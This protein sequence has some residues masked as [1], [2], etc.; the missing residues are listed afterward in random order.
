[1]ETEGRSITCALQVVLPL[2][3][4]SFSS[5]GV[6]FGAVLWEVLGLV[7]VAVALGGLWRVHRLTLVLNVGHEATVLVGG[8]GHRL[9]AAVGKID[10]VGP[11]RPSAKNV[12]VSRKCLRV[13]NCDTENKPTKN[14]TARVLRL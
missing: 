5:G 12:R 3:K 1:M 11:C 13:P 8:V 10:S 2:T 6:V 4:A 14:V 7:R 9:N